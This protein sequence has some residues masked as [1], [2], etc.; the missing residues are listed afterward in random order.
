M[1]CQS[2][3]LASSISI[4]ACLYFQGVRGCFLIQ[5]FAFSNPSSRQSAEIAK[6]PCLKGST[7]YEDAFV[8]SFLCWMS[9][10]CYKGAGN[11]YI[12]HGLE[13]C[14]VVG[15]I[16]SI[17][18]H[19]PGKLHAFEICSLVGSIAFSIRH[20]NYIYIRRTHIKNIYQCKR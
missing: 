1:L 17:I 5:L 15:S 6:F 10:A 12:V 19:Q 16:A 2:P 8:I 3:R 7:P 11:I 9:I 14:S 13:I 4:F 20:E 18:K